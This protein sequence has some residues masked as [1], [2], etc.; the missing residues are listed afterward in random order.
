MC[1]AIPGLVKKI[2]GK[3]VIVDYFGQERK[4]NNELTGLKL[5]D[6]VYAQ[7]GYLIQTIS[8]KEALEI[9]DAWRETFFDLQ[10]VDLQLAGL[11]LDKHPDAD[12][13]LIKILDKATKDTPLDRSDLKFLLG[14]SRTQDLELFY[15]TATFLRQKHL[16]NSCCVHG[17][18]EISNYCSRSCAYCGISSLNKQVARY[19]L[20][21]DQIVTLAKSAVNDYGFKALVLQSG[22]DLEYSV[23]FLVEV[24]TE[25]KKEAACLIFISFGEIG[26]E[27]L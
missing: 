23:D 3:T 17:I 6:Y 14:L 9:L 20:N 22:E 18:L 21:K 5:G 8:K 13:N 4:A 1:Y 2:D 19:R 12:R 15:K 26:L 27:G 16:G 25:I 24:V 10:D 7:G 11:D